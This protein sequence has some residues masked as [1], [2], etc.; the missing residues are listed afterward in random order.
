MMEEWNLSS[1]Q[2]GAVGS[3][4]LFGMMMGALILAP[5][6]DKFGRKKYF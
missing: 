3:Y 2:A 6:A 1:V 5:I 4:S